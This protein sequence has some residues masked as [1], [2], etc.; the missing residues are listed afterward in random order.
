MKF[1]FLLI[2]FFVLVHTGSSQDALKKISEIKAKGITQVGVDRL[3]NFFTV[4]SGGAIKKFDPNGKVLEKLKVGKVN[5]TLLEGWYHP[6]IFIYDRKK[7]TVTTFDRHFESKRETIID[8]S[9]AV[10]PFL[11]CPRGD[12][13]MLVLDAGD[14]SIKLVNPFGNTVQS[15]FT[16][17]RSVISESP[18]FVYMREYQNM[19]FLLD[20][21]K[22]II[23]LNNIGKVITTIPAPGL[24][25]F[26]FFG[27]EIYFFH[28]QKLNFFDLYTEEVRSVPMNKNY[29][30]VLAT[31]ERIITISEKNTI[32]LFELPALLTK[33]N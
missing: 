17:D 7:Q 13:R 22:G 18:E 19:I 31:D 11:I 14:Y 9:I 16:I 33:K 12:N 10:E 32:E 2:S 23:I 29:R 6:T 15:E 28:D 3:G 5:V 25:N 21:K 1:I 4:T 30:F 8:P 27:E 26:N 20:R 24:S